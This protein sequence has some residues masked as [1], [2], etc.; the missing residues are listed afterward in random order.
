M[1]KICSL[2]VPRQDMGH[3]RLSHFDGKS[4]SYDS[5]FIGWIS[6]AGKSE[7]QTLVTAGWRSWTSVPLYV[8]ETEAEFIAWQ[9][10]WG[11]FAVA[12]PELIRTYFSSLFNHRD[13]V[14]EDPPMEKVKRRYRRE[15]KKSGL[16]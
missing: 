8:I 9:W 14:V 16:L 6:M 11:S 5:H 12:L 4:I 15:Q 1:K 10:N 13:C 7:C 3:I 2:R